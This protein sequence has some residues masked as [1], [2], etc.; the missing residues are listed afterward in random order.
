MTAQQTG[1]GRANAP[2]GGERS[3]HRAGRDCSA[4]AEVVGDVLADL[5]THAV[6]VRRTPEVEYADPRSR[7]PTVPEMVDRACDRGTDAGPLPRLFR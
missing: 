4:P 2:N 6:W 1:N 3:D 7:R 5:R